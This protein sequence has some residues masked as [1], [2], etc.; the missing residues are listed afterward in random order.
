MSTACLDIATKALGLVFRSF[1]KAFPPRRILR[2][3]LKGKW[4]YQ[5]ENLGADLQRRIGW[6][7]R[8]RAWSIGSYIRDT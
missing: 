3:T 4:D 7:Q 2:E 5:A 8:E 6:K 1:G